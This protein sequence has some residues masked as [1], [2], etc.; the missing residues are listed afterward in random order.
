MEHDNK[1]DICSNGIAFFLRKTLKKGIAY[2]YETESNDI[3][4]NLKNK[5][6]NP[7][8]VALRAFY[9]SHSRTT[10]AEK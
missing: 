10:M 8:M 4:M 9:Y 3:R 7:V 6:L 2:S 5:P 1:Y